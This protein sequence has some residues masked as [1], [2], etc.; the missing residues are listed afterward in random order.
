M[1]CG[2]TRKKSEQMGDMA[3][4]KKEGVIESRRKWGGSGVDTR[5]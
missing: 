3:E 2:V 5:E 4:G 1:K